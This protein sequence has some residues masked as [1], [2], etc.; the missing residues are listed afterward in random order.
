MA[1]RQQELFGELERHERSK[2]REFWGEVCAGIFFAVFLMLMF[3]FPVV[4][5]ALIN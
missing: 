5:H 3:Y 1:R 2:R 4:I